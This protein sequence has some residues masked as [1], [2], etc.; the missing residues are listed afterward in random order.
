MQPGERVDVVKRVAERLAVEDEW[1]EIDLI[2]EQFGFPTSLSWNDDKKSYLIE[3]LKDGDSAN[4]IAIDQY[5]MGH[6]RPSDEPWEGKSF[7]LFLTHVA[8]R[9]KVAHTLKSKLQYFGVDAFVAHKDIRAG[10]EWQVV[11]ESALASCDA[12][13]GLLHDGF[14]KSDWCDQEVGIAYGRGI[15]VVPIQYDLLPYG[16]FGS[17]QAV[18]NARDLTAESLAKQLVEILLMDK[19]TSHRLT[20]SIVCCLIEAGS[21]D[22]AN[23]LSQLLATDAPLVSRGQV[24]RLR[25][26]EKTNR[27]L[28]EA[29]HFD[30]HLKSIENN[31]S[32]S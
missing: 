5:L 10:K 18:L 15:P 14:R 13:A 1:T 9:K 3:H 6:H 19:R 8:K 22:Q 32:K 31:L 26:A 23:D 30:H 28:N 21:F 16:F 7:R 20:E 24:K 29:F 12:L 2:L 4:L 11:I 17:L 25:R 27:Q